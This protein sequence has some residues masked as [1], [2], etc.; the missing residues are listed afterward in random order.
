MKRWNDHDVYECVCGFE[1]TDKDAFE[2]HLKRIGVHA[3][4]E[5]PIKEEPKPARRKKEIETRE[6]ENN[7]NQVE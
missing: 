5:E 6:E 7:V 3:Q 4:K 2:A 1:T